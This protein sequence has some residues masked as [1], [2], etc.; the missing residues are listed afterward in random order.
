MSS[1]RTVACLLRAGALLLLLAASASAQDIQAMQAWS[2]AT[3]PGTT[4]GVGYVMLHNTGKQPRVLVAAAS[5]VAG[6]VEMHESR[7]ANSGLA[8]MRPLRKLV[9]P[10]GGALTFEPSGKHL[11]LVGLKAPLVAGQRVPVTFQFQTGE[12]VTVELEVRS[13]TDTGPA[14]ADHHHPD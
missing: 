12:P 13:L 14:A 4:V 6:A 8:E 9:V 7:L 11:M 2:R 10:A 5:P 1:H 3:P